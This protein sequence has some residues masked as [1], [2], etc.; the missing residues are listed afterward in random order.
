MV[1]CGRRMCA[2]EWRVVR[3]VPGLPIEQRRRER[4]VDISGSEV[5]VETEVEEEDVEVEDS[6]LE[7]SRSAVSWSC[8]C[9]CCWRR[10]CFRLPLMPISAARIT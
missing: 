8:I 1:R 5:G 7:R 4:I 2:A 3:R 6:A 9:C 10:C